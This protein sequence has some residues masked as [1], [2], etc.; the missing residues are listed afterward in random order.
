MRKLILLFAT[1]IALIAA[2]PS[3]AATGVSITKTG[4]NPSDATVSAGG[5]VTWTNN[6]ATNHQIVANDGSFSSPVLAPKQSYSHTFA[7]TGSNPYHDA[8]DPTLKATV[9]VV[10]GG[11]VSI[12]KDG[13]TPAE[14]IVNAAG[15]VTWT[16]KDTANHQVV[17][18]GGGFSSPVLATGQ[19]YTHTFLLPGT[20]AYHDGL[21]PSSK[22][23]VVVVAVTPP[24]A[25]ESISLGG[26]RLLVV[27]GNTTTLSGKIDNG[28]AGEKVTI[29][30]KPQL[31]GKVTQS[32]QTVIAGADGS[33]S[34][35]V[36]PL[37]HTT[38]V[39]STDKSR[40][41]A[42]AINVAPKLG[43]GFLSRTRFI[44]RATA[45]RSLVGKYGLLQKR[46]GQV[47]VSMRRV[48]LARVSYG[49]AQ[50]VVS[51]AI[52]RLHLRH[53]LSLRVLMPLGQTVPGY[54]S[55]SSNTTRS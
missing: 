19:S 16:N 31:A 20:H 9:T 39:A 23:S 13:F 5:R 47:W 35:V 28:T 46:V 30:A 15:T 3:V 26:D 6:D 12:T 22:G 32:T 41:D 54:A 29:T 17:G 8:I 53:G 24:P 42:V 10:A 50:N 51:S 43:A 48:Y 18:N 1:V 11:Q 52:V 21:Q 40:S 45:A 55:A 34:A 14:T 27:Y 33:F 36:Q 2:A 37:I 44:F 4:F 49:P 25:S 38:Y 7:S